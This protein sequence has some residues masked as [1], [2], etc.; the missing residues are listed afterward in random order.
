[1]DNTDNAVVGIGVGD[2]VTVWHYLL[3]LV[4]VVS[5]NQNVFIK[6]P[7]RPESCFEVQSMEVCWSSIGDRWIR[8]VPDDQNEKTLSKLL[9]RHTGSVKWFLGGDMRYHL[10]HI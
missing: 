7:S 10:C 8:L 4:I 3:K 1:M 5:L 6:L 9:R 2:Q